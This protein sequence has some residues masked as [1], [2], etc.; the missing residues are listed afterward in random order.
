MVI[1][2]N[3]RMMSLIYLVVLYIM[4]LEYRE[5]KTGKRYKFD[6]K[7]I[8]KVGVIFITAIFIY[9]YLVESIPWF[10]ENGFIG[11]EI[12][13][14]SDLFD[15]SNSQGRNEI[16]SQ[17]SQVFE[18]FNIREKLIGGS[19]TS[20]KAIVNGQLHDSHNTYL[21][22]LFCTGYIGVILF[23]S[24]LIISIYYTNHIKDIE[25]KYTYIMLA[26]TYMISGLSNSNIVFTQQTWIFMFYMGILVNKKNIDA[27]KLT[28]SN[29]IN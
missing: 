9:S 26:I 16:W 25:F 3:S 2:S 6:L 24:L 12:N 14:I 8:I 29:R 19:I 5:I 4:Y 21:K 15:S 1:L 27:K 23:C 13:N 10:K 20:D 11:F 18:G 17:L 28:Y 22:L 7:L